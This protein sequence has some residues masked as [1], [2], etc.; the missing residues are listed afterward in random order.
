MDSE[1]EQG[2][3]GLRS[4]L[5]S[6]RGRA[7]ST[8][9]T[10]RE[11]SPIVDG[12]VHAWEHDTA[13]GGGIMAGALAFR[14]FFF[15][16]PY[17]LFIFTLLGTAS[18]VSETSASD[19]A[20]KAGISGVLAKGVINTNTLS[21]GQ[22][23]VLLIVSGYATFM[24]ARSVVKTIVDESCL[25]WQIPRVKMRRF[26][27]TVLFIVFITVV[28]WLTSELGTLRAS[29][30]APGILL[31]V[32]WMLLPLIAGWWLM[33][34]LPHGN[35]PNWALLPGAVIFAVGLQV[36]HLFTVFYIARYASSKS[37]TYGVVGVA[38]AALLWCYVAGRLVIGT[39]V[40]NAAL[41]RRYEAKHPEHRGDQGHLDGLHL[42]S[43]VN[44][45]VRESIDLFR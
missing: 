20:R 12:I 2:P 1:N 7:T 29:M 3:S 25:V 28:S 26:R 13:V 22:K 33:A 34:K 44:R 6:A 30:P 36:M 9:R 11:R 35:A 19:M 31:T 27:P 14:V 42:A 21:T 39:A 40:F 10:V 24:A 37:E 38:L 5:A 8:A 15:L 23:W 17:V 18:T 16:V 32:A 45:W 41:W 43:R 4:S